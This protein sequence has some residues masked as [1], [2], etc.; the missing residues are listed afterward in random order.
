[1]A[2]PSSGAS[3]I[4]TSAQAVENLL[5]DACG[6]RNPTATAPESSC[7][8][9]VAEREISPV[10]NHFISQQA[11]DQQHGAG[12]VVAAGDVALLAGL[13]ACAGGSVA[14]VLSPVDSAMIRLPIAVLS[15]AYD[16]HTSCIIAPSCV[17]MIELVKLSPTISTIIPASARTEMPA[18]MMFNCGTVFPTNPRT[19]IDDQHGDEHGRGQLHR[20]H[21]RALKYRNDRVQQRAIHG[22]RSA[23]ASAAKLSKTPLTI[24]RWPPMARKIEQRQE[25]IEIADDR[26]PAAELRVEGLAEVQAHLLCR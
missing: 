24:A 21:R 4:D 17:R 14:S 23:A 12:Q 16:C 3:A 26:T 2:P 11:A 15:R 7:C 6:G 19:M 20:Q 13:R 1:M 9:H 5:P 8:N 22:N 10:P 18:V 25:E